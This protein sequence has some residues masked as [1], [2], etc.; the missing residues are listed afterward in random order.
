MRLEKTISHFF[1]FAAAMS[2]WGENYPI[3]L[4]LLVSN[5]IFGLGAIIVGAIL[6]DWARFPESSVQF[7]NWLKSEQVSEL[8]NKDEVD[9]MTESEANLHRAVYTIGVLSI[10]FGLIVTAVGA[11]LC[12]MLCI[13]D[14]RSRSSMA[15]KYGSEM[16]KEM[17][18]VV[19]TEKESN[20]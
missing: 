10:I 2:N 5:S 4:C 15:G 6:I 9:E 1:Y 7:F 13:R 12:Y 11:D 17:S 8:K 20:D 19:A 16:D 3:F 14:R 18:R